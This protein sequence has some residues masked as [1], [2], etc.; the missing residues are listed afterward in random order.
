MDQL[1]LMAM[2]Q[3]ANAQIAALFAQVI[4]INFAMIVAIHVFLHR[5]GRTLKVG[6]FL[7]YLIGMLTLIGQM[8]QQANIKGIATTTL[9][10]IATAR[11]S[12]VTAG[13]LTVNDSWVFT[14]SR[15]FENA[16]LWLL[17]AVVGYLLFWWRKSDA[18]Q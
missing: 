14:A 12:P 4:T 1:A 16:A 6:A 11:R 9:A 5:A 3:E 18:D 8:L 2:L 17:I 13:Y 10:G 7:F 15:V